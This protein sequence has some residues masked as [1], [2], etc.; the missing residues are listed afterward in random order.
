MREPESNLTG[1]DSACKD[2]EN[3]KCGATRPHTPHIP[4]SSSSSAVLTLNEQMERS[5]MQNSK[6]YARYDSS[7][8]SVPN[9]SRLFVSISHFVLLSESHFVLLSE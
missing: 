7:Y 2:H 1:A 6:L 3:P 4:P 8:K 5:Y 9:F